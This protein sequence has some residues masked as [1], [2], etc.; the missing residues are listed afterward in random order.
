MITDNRLERAFTEGQKAKAGGFFD[1]C[2][3]AGDKW[4]ELYWKAGYKGVKFEDVLE[5][6][7]K[8]ESA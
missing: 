7:E 1:T 4:R 2:P 5:N 3:Y 6:K 8:I